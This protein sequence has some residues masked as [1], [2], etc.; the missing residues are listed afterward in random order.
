MLLRTVVKLGLWLGNTWR[1]L[2]GL[3][4]LPG[5]TQG[6]AAFI[7]VKLSGR[8]YS[9]VKWQVPADHTSR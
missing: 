6:L 7:L 2:E 1:G 8:R 5:C 9:E 3:A 4:V